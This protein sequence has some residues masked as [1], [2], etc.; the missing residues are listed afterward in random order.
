M[1]RRIVTGNNSDG[2][3]Y[4]VH[5]GPTPGELDLGMVV[6]EEVWVDNPS[7]SEPVAS[8]DP[9][10]VEAIQ[11]HPPVNGSL[12]RIVTFPPMSHSPSL[13]PE[14][15]AANFSRFE[16]GGVMEEDN[17]GMHTTRTIDYQIILSG[18]IDLEL[19]EGEVHLKAGDIVV[20][21]ATRHGWFNRGTEPCICAAVMINSPNY[22]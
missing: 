8:I 18:E 12:V 13:S 17:P 2:K 5:D 11:L 7:S 9:A 20:Q 14:D 21:R 4:F 19:D 3:S 1:T 6:I 15:L 22:R 10:N 16:T